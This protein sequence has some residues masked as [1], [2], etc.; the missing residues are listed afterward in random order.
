VSS[1][2]VVITAT[3]LAEHRSACQ[4]ENTVTSTVPKKVATSEVV[5]KANWKLV[6]ENFLECYHCATAHLESAEVVDVWGMYGSM[7]DEWEVGE[8]IPGACNLLKEGMKTWAPNGAYVNKKFGEFD[9]GVEPEQGFAAAFLTTPAVWWL[10]FHPD[11]GATLHLEPVSVEETR[12]GTNW[13]VNKD[14]VEGEDYDVDEMAMLLNIVNEQDR[15]ICDGTQRGMRSRRFSPGPKQREARS[16]AT[17]HH[18][19]LLAHDGRGVLR[20]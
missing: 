17:R 16:S 6:L 2:S 1:T 10:C 4:A 7:G 13:W 9:R 15:K 12:W 11:F 5:F 18:Q 20:W 8:Y 19:H 3:F 14:A